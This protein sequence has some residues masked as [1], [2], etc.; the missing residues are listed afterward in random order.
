MN[1]S[2]ADKLPYWHFHNDV[3][4][5]KDGSLGVGFKVFGRDIGS[6]SDEVINQI[7][8]QIERLLI[9]TDEELRFQLHYDLS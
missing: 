1:K 3:M 2:L 7:N 5:Y 8:R 9:S 4:V 6:A